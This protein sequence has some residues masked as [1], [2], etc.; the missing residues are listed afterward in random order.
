ME[1]GKKIAEKIKIY[2]DIFGSTNGKAVLKDIANYCGLMRS[3]FVNSDPIAMA[4]LEGRR[5]VILE[6]IRIIKTDE[7][8]LDAL[9]DSDFDTNNLI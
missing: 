8:Y 5:E 6:I 3:S 7:K 4:R 2:K 9:I 1:Q